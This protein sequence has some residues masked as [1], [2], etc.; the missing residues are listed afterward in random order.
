MKTI[1]RE[2]FDKLQVGD[3]LKNDSY[4]LIVEA[5]FANN[6]IVL[7]NDYDCR[8]LS[9]KE[10]KEKGYSIT[11][12]IQHNCGFPYGDYS[13][14]EVIVKVSDESIEDCE[15]YILYARLISVNEKGF[16]DNYGNTWRFAVLVSNNVDLVK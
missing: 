2:Q 4:T 1:T 5:K 15:V 10:L 9:L 12:P 11:K 3:T 14:R 8:F 13:D 6:I 16:I 7:D